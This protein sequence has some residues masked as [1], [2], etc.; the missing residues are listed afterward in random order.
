MREAAAAA[1]FL[2]GK[3][4]MIKNNAPYGKRRGCPQA[5]LWLSLFLSNWRNDLS[6][7]N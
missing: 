5:V 7:P 1:F 4:G 2:P 3:Y 6:T